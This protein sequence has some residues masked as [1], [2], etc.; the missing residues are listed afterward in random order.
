MR[1]VL[2]RSLSGSERPEDICPHRRLDIQASASLRNRP[3]NSQG[4]SVACQLPVFAGRSVQFRIG[5]YAQT[6]PRRWKDAPCTVVVPEEKDANRTVTPNRLNT[7]IAGP[8]RTRVVEL[9][10]ANG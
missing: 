7:D 10:D 2:S 6:H 5:G 4:G 8:L 9:R 3:F 1:V